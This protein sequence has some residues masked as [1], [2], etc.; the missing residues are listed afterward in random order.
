M[1]PRDKVIWSRECTPTMA[2]A[3]APLHEKVRTK[4]AWILVLLVMGSML[5]CRGPIYFVFSLINLSIL[6]NHTVSARHRA[7]LQLGE[8]VG[9]LSTF[10]NCAFNKVRTSCDRNF[11]SNL[12]HDVYGSIRLRHLYRYRAPQMAQ[13]PDCMH[14]P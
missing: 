4:T 2:V 7:C 12:G 11:L 13:P 8:K 14:A 9:S 3:A 1:L 6:T 5:M 10:S